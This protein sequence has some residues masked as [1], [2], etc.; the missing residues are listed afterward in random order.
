MF[1]YFN[2]TVAGIYVGKSFGRST[3]SNAIEGLKSKI[4]AEGASESLMAQLCGDGRNGDHVFGIAVDTTGNLAS[5]QQSVRS[6]REAQCVSDAEREGQLQSLRVLESTVDLRPVSNFTMANSTLHRR[7]DCT[8][9]T[10]VSG[11]TCSTLASKCGISPSDFTKYNSD[12]SICSSLQPGQRVCCSSGTLPDIRP[13]KNPDGTCASYLVQSNDYCA[14]IA[15]TNGLT[16]DDIESFNTGKNGTWGWAGCDKLLLGMN[17]CLSEGKPPNPAPQADAICGPTVPD[18][19]F[20]QIGGDITVS[21]LNPC[22]L[23][24][25]CN[26]WGHCG[27]DQDFCV[28]QRA[29]TGNPGTSTGQNGCVSSCGF[30]IKKS[31]SAPAGFGRIGYYETWNFERPCLNMRVSTAS[32]SGTYTHLHWAFMTIDTS[33]WTPVVNDTFAQWSEFKAITTSKRIASFGGW[34][35][36]TEP[37]TYDILPEGMSAANRG[38]FSDNIVKFINDEGLDG[39]D[40]DWE[41]PGATDIPGTPAGFETD[42]PNYLKFLITLKGKMPA[43]KTLSIAAPASYWYLRGFPI[44]LMSD[45]VDYIVYMTYDLHGQWDAGNQYS[46]YGCPTGNCLRSHVNRT[47]QEYALSMITKAGVESNKIFVGE[48]SYGRS[49]HMAENSCVGPTCLFTGDRD[50]SDAAP[51]PCTNVAGY[52][53]NAEIEE[54]ISYGWGQQVFE[55]GD[56]ASNILVYNDTQWVAYMSEDVKTTRRNQWQGYNFA[57]TID[58]AI[59]LQEYTDDDGFFSNDDWDWYWEYPDEPPGI[60]G[61]PESQ[62]QCDNSRSYATLDDIDNDSSISLDCRA[63]YVLEVLA[64]NLTVAMAHYDD[65]IKNKYDGKFNTYADAVVKSASKSVKNFMLGHGNDYFDCIVTE[66]TFCCD[67]CQAIAPSFPGACTYCFDGGDCYCHPTVSTCQHRAS[68]R[69]LRLMSTR[70]NGGGAG[71]LTDP[72][73]IFKNYSEPC[74]PDYSKRGV[75]QGDPETDTTWWSMRPDRE[76][77]FYADIYAATSIDRDN[78]KIADVMNGAWDCNDFDSCHWEHWDMGIVVPNGYDKDDVLNPK[79]T[80]TAAHDNLVDVPSQL[81]TIIGQIKGGTYEGSADDLVDTLAIPLAMLEE[82]LANMDLVVDI[83]DEIEEEKRKA[84]IL[85]F[86]SAILFFIPMVGEVASALGAAAA[87][88]RIAALLGEIGNAA[89][90][91]YSIVDDPSNAPLAIFLLVTGAVSLLDVAKIAKAAGF[92]RAVA[93]EDVG[94]LGENVATKVQKIDRVKNFCKLNAR[95]RSVVTAPVGAWPMSSLDGRS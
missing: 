48:S 47:E 92:R 76:E 62:I 8:T 50:N 81:T 57:G 14:A 41:Y 58:W 19:D 73:V 12:S 17:I 6:W 16:V 68:K 7:S 39:V 20:S 78:L 83:A 30:D 86:L 22:P 60:V 25:C 71:I 69:D 52:I 55:D 21:D 91:I 82:A 95:K 64:N 89:L 67:E 42:G 59:D 79:D 38:K 54:I 5:V 88:A 94:K 49:F 31:D 37:A 63:R 40:F 24:V 80:A 28:E 36:S 34:G 1:A 90:D 85:A 9:T 35:Y 43:G 3:I 87:I 46:Q 13:Q 74:P 26:I 27:M 45:T 2:N 23:N 29:K 51:G 93:E 61:T 15:V 33:T 77:Q 72:N 53:S 18:T 11:D 10:V 75:G 65:L 84:I 56:S 70:D 66:M 4:G 44:Q 32:N